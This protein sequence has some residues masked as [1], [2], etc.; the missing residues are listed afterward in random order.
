MSPNQRLEKLKFSLMN[1]DTMNDNKLPEYNELTN[2]NHISF[3]TEINVKNKSK[4][5]ILESDQ[6]YIWK[7]I[8]TDFAKH[9]A[10]IAIRY[11]RKYCDD[12]SIDILE[13]GFIERPERNQSDKSVIQYMAVNVKC[14]RF[15]YKVM[16]IYRT[17]DADQNSLKI[18]TK[19]LFNIID[20]INPDIALGDFNIDFK[21]DNNKFELNQLCKMKQIVGAYTRIQPSK[22]N[23]IS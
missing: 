21:D 11:P 5:T 2:D 22:N 12:I 17:P 14:W 6:T 13:Q 18:N 9:D 16:L 7:F 1:V 20:R 15:G 8:E 4:Q 19:N 23:N 3:I 10:R